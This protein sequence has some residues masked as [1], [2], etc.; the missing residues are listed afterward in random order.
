[1]T[2]RQ[3]TIVTRALAGSLALWAMAL[4]GL[5]LGANMLEAITIVR[6]GGTTGG[7]SNFSLVQVVGCLARAASNEGWMLTK[8]SA[9]VVTKEESPAAPFESVINLTSLHGLNQPCQQR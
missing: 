4:T 3:S 1:M 5:S 6:R 2:K 8:A 7:V 9:P